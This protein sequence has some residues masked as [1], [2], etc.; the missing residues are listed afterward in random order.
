MSQWFEETAAGRRKR[1][2]IP[3]D[4]RFKT[5]I[6]LAMEMLD[7]AHERGLMLFQWVSGDCAYGDAHEFRKHVAE[8]GKWYC[9][10]VYYDTHVWTDDPAWKVPPVMENRRGR[11]PK[12]PKPT[13]GSPPAVTAS[14]LVSS[15]PDHQWQ[16]ICL[17]EGDKG[18]REIVDP[19]KAH[20]SMACKL[21][22]VG[23]L[24]FVQG[25]QNGK[26]LIRELHGAFL[27]QVVQC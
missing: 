6:E 13:E 24:L 2:G 11:K 25:I 26:G 7:R 5:K 15:I 18:P 8:L 12:H 1:A 14:S 20:S 4:V 3:Q 17:R 16:R 19:A 21:A 10:E 27:C 9:F 22:L 23:D